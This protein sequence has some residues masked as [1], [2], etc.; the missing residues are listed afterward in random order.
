MR[1]FNKAPENSQELKFHLTKS[2]EIEFL[3]NDVEKHKDLHA[4]EN[5]FHMACY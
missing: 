2:M 3:K 4:L 5:S 1:A